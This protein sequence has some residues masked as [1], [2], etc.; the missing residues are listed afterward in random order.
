M[1]IHYTKYENDCKIRINRFIKLKK[2]KTDY[3]TVKSD[4]AKFMNGEYVG[5]VSMDVILQFRFNLEYIYNLN[6]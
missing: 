2:L 5:S 1:N 3:E 6:I 4:F